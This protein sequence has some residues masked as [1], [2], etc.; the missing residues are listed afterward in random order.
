MNYIDSVLTVKGKA[1]D[2]QRDAALGN[3]LVLLNV[4]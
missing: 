4:V 1:N 3:T 2:V